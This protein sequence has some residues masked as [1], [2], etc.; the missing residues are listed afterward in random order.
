M[1]TLFVTAAVFGVLTAGAA[2]AGTVDSAAIDTN[3]GR[4]GQAMDGG[5]YRVAFPRTDLAVKIGNVRLLPGL[6]LGGYAAFVPAADRALVVGDLVL[7]DGEIQP[8]MDSLEKSGFQITALHNHLRNEQPHVMYM[9]ILAEGDAGVLA[10]HLRDALALSKTP[11]G[12]MAKS[13]AQ[14]LAFKDAIESGIGRTGKVNGKVLSIAVARPE[15]IVMDGVT[16]PPAAGVATSFN[17]QDAGNGNIA[18]TG[19]FVLIPSEVA[20]VQKALLAHGFEVTA[21]HSHLIDDTP[22]LFYMHFWAVASPAAIAT[23]LSDALQHV[24]VKP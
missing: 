18:T 6:A 12:P 22:H 11:L 20:A 3:I 1:R 10:K 9:H 8:V 19:D 23:G 15:A 2:V 21:F 13:A 16:I 7:L 4:S 17:F 5:V 14:P 24:G